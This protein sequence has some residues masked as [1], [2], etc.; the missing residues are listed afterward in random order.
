[1]NSEHAIQSSNAIDAIE[2]KKE[3]Q[4]KGNEFD[5]AREWPYEKVSVLADVD[6]ID[7]DMDDEMDLPVIFAEDWMIVPE[8]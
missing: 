6:D 2:W 4:N 1:M 7:D 8:E 5:E 3:V